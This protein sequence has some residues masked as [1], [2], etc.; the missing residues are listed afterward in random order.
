MKAT[1]KLNETYEVPV[2]SVGEDVPED[3][4]LVRFEQNLHDLLHFDA[5]FEL[6]VYHFDLKVEDLVFAGSVCQ[7]MMAA[8][9]DVSSNLQVFSVVAVVDDPGMLPERPV[10]ANPIGPDRVLD[11][12]VGVHAIECV[13]EE[14]RVLG[15]QRVVDTNTSD[16]LQVRASDG[17]D[18]VDPVLERRE[19]PLNYRRAASELRCGQ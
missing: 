1:S 15:A 10:G 13:G 16:I 7:F 8:R 6:C 5:G 19:A 9:L 11:H 4:P 14:R 18:T 12:D 17:T 3:H 2:Q